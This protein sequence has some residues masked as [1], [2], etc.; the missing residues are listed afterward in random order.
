MADQVQ[1][2]VVNGKYRLL[3]KLGEGAMGTVSL[4]EQLDV[5]GRVLRQVALKTMRRELSA[6]PAF[7]KRF[8][9][10]VRIATQLRSPH[11]VMVHDSGQGEDGQL[12]FIMEY[13][14]GPTLRQVLR[15]H[16]PLPIERVIHVASQI[17][18]ALIEAHSL[19][20][21]VVHRDLKPPNIFVEQRQGKDWVKI[22]DFGIA[23]ILSE[24]TMGLTQAGQ[25]SSGTPS[26]MAPEQWRGAGEDG[27]T[28]LYALGV[29]MYE[30]L[31]GRPPFASSSVE[32]LMHQH[33]TMPPPPL[34]ATVPANLRALI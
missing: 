9:R 22:G 2:K 12:Y 14:N 8:L 27:R 31:T 29:I 18:E 13:I 16:S 32:A 17:C 24:H 23:K 21:P 6:D 26:Y 3:A 5:E 10:E 33:L 1:R 30:M 4:A 11:T 28:D 20:D 34:P 7:A 15:Q 19:P 25:S